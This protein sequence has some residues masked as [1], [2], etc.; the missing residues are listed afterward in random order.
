MDKL[1][2]R[3][4]IQT[5]NN[6]SHKKSLIISSF[7]NGILLALICPW[8][9]LL[10][11][12]LYYKPDKELIRS[13]KS[14]GTRITKAPHPESYSKIVNLMITDIFNMNIGSLHTKF[15]PIHLSFFKIQ[16][17]KN[18]F[19]GPE[20]F[21]GLSENGPHGSYKWDFTF[22]YVYNRAVRL[23]QSKVWS[24]KEI[25]PIDNDDYWCICTS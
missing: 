19:A 23:M 5:F 1:V 24:Q 15:R 20:M 8:Y 25:K 10:F 14:P 18:G 4:H 17:S 7:P 11:S 6:M 12:R 3:V 13:W 2:N 22:F 16:I 21:P 9:C